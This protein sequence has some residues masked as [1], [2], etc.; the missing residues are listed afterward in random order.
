MKLRL[1]LVLLAMGLLLVGAKVFAEDSPDA[2][3]T[4]QNLRS[5]LSQVQDKEAELKNRLEQLD[6]DLK[7]ENIE[8]YFNGYGSVHPEELREQRRKQL[9]SEKNR[10]TSQLDQL[11]S[12][13]TRLETAVANAQAKAYQQSGL[14]KASLTP[15]PERRARVLTTGRLLIGMGVL[16][17]G[18]GGVG[19]R[20][21]RRRKS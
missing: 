17:I 11:A 1:A 9:Q 19:W 14:G 6:Y 16:I 20:L 8:R 10:I 7:P 3:Q 2:F 12:D 18:L 15:N 4:L 5:Q 21:R 13:R